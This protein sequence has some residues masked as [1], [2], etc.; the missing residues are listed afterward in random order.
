MKVPANITADRLML[1]YLARVAAAGTR[2]LPK[3][4]R[5]AF[6]GKTRQRIERE[7]GPGL[8]DADCMRDVLARLGEPEELVKAERARLD[9]ARVRRQAPDEETGAAVAESITEPLQ[10]RPIHSRWRPATH[11][12]PV[13]QPQ[14]GPGDTRPG[15]PPETGRRPAREGMVR[16]RL[17]ALL[18]EWPGARWGLRA[19]GEPAAGPGQSGP[20][21][22]DGTSAA[23]Q[24][25]EGAAPQAD[26]TASAQAD[27]S[28][29]RQVPEGAPAQAAGSPSAPTPEAQGEDFVAGAPV[30][31]ATPAGETAPMGTAP[32]ED[33]GPGET[34]AADEDPVPGTPPAGWG[35]PAAPDEPLEGKV[36]PPVRAEADG[37]GGPPGAGTRPQAA[38]PPPGWSAPVPV[39]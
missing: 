7:C 14:P 24:A 1:E 22:P 33:A 18:G 23:S 29:A 38:T 19:R 27:R 28:A 12:R 26:E 32:V 11:V 13:G 2:Y 21:G 8:G 9:A 36:L 30:P 5:M 37:A 15:G 6:V 39:S 3:G 34:A 17:A 31:D 20:A 16:G 25:A 10:H 4:A 35:T